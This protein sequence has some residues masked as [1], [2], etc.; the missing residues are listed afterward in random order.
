MSNL[1]LLKSFKSKLL[2][3]FPDLQDI[4]FYVRKQYTYIELSL[5]AYTTEGM[6]NL[7]DAVKKTIKKYFKGKL[8]YSQAGPH[9]ESIFI[10][11][12]R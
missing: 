4:E 2:K 10:L 6:N 11:I 8:K 9:E 12:V 5:W 3:E 7:D 1:S